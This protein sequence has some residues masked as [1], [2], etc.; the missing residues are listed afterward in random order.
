MELCVWF[1]NGATVYFFNVR[2]EKPSEENQL[3]FSY[4]GRSSKKRKKASFNTKN[5]AGYSISTAD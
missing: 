1:K 5:I 3:E 2:M 4:F